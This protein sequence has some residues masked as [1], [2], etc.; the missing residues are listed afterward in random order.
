MT[1]VVVDSSVAYKWLDS[2]GE[3][4]VE[5]A[6][7]LLLEHISGSIALAAP[8]ILHV[9]LAN[10]LR[11]SPHVDEEQT[12]A[13]VEELDDLHIALAKPTSN[14]LETAVR[15]SY[16]H[17]ISVCDALFLA[18]AAELQCPLVTA[19]RRAFARVDSDVEIRL[20]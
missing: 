6:N 15:F 8:S 12:L 14:R 18:L 20:I 9:E 13:L 3:E 19:D 1:Y 16:R 11:S 2:S 17:D 5:S 7:A 4:G 10:A